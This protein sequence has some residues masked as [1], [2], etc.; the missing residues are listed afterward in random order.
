M[1]LSFGDLI[2]APDLA[3]AMARALQINSFENFGGGIFSI[4]KAIFRDN[5]SHLFHKQYSRIQSCI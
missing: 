1:V 2:A 4:S 5:S 3:S